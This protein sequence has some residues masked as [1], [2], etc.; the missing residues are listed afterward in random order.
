MFGKK[1]D[2]GADSPA[3]AKS[4][5]KANKKSFNAQEFLLFHAEKFVFG[6]IALLAIGLIYLGA[7]TTSFDSSKTPERLSQ[8]SQ[9]T[10]QQI[11]KD[12]WEAIR[13]EEPRVKGVTDVSYAAKAVE[14]T[15]PVAPLAIGIDPGDPSRMRERRSDPGVLA[16]RQLEAKYFFGPIVISSSNAQQLAVA[17]FLNKLEDSK[18]KEEP[19]RDPPRGGRGGSPPGYPGGGGGP[20]GGYPGGAGGGGAPAS[21]AG[22][23]KYLAQGYDRGFPSHTLAPPSDTKKKLVARDVGF[24]S[25]MALAPHQ[26]LEV[27]YRDKL[28][29]AGSIMPGRDT[30]NYVGFEVQRVDVTDDPTKAIQESDWQPLPNANSE[31]IKERSKSSWLGTNQEVVASDWTMPNLTMPIPPV[32]LKDYRSFVTHTEVPKSGEAVVASAPP[33]GGLGGMGGP[34]GDTGFG[35]QGFGGAGGAPP[36]YPGGGGGGAPPGYPGGGGGPPS[37]YA[38]GSGGGGGGGAPPGYPGGGGGPPAGYGGGAGGGP[39]PGYGGGAGG[40]APPGYGGSM[41]GPPGF[42]GSSATTIIAPTAD[43]PKEL[44]STKYKLVRFYDFE[45]KSNRVYR[46]RVRLLMYDPNFPEAASIQPRSST[47]DVA[48]GTLKRIQD[49]LEIER[50][51]LDSRKPGDGKPPYKRNSSRPSD[52]SEASPPV[53][54]VR[55]MDG[56]LGE[57][58]I[59]YSMDRDRKIFEASTPRADMVMVDYDSANGIFVPRKDTISRGYV[60]GLPNKDAGRDA[61]IEIIH[62]ITKL[63]KLLDNRETKNLAAVIDL[64]GFVPLEVKVPRDPHLKSGAKAA[65]YDPV[66]NRLVIMREFDDFTGY[67]MHTE[68]EKKAVGPLGGPLKLDAGSAAGP[69]GGGAAGGNAGG[70]GPGLGGRSG[71]GPGIGGTGGGG[72][73]GGGGSGSNT[74]S[75]EN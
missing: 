28:A 50:K 3:P 23:K 69:Y 61:P 47:L 7:I 52:W 64:V 14:A 15:K 43:T 4:P 35:S 53:A 42:G 58:K 16:A 71:G 73:G 41:G 19:K 30:P 63:I 66:S 46:Y 51:E 67:G 55:T 5:S 6:L 20:P 49:L 75:S 17:D 33:P 26:E 72:G 13:N 18:V 22:A 34:P 74:T 29:R 24:V 37:G 12:H 9:D 1:K 11:S 36:G 60:F 21:Q 45:A 31:I 57:P 8:Q 62:P 65:A 32:L 68:P 70:A 2:K 54:T 38:G 27:E 25:V 10:L 48:S 39:P 40:G 56:Y 44:P 59:V